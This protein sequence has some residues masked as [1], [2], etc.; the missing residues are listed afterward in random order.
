MLQAL[1][2]AVQT[3]VGSTKAPAA[4]L[5]LRSTTEAHIRYGSLNASQPA[6]YSHPQLHAPFWMPA[7]PPTVPLRPFSAWACG[8]CMHA[9]VAQH[10]VCIGR[11]LDL[12]SLLLLCCVMVVLGDRHRVRADGG[13]TSC[14]CLSVS[15]VSTGHVGFNPRCMQ[16]LA[17]PAARGCLLC[18]VRLLVGRHHCRLAS[19][20]QPGCSVHCP[21]LARG[22]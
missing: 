15:R 14:I 20:N 11:W 17:L 12:A 21:R 16:G 9:L 13:H 22:P 3:C 7:T 5:G 19:C 18:Q 2:V 10:L 4:T 8:A 1:A 6:M